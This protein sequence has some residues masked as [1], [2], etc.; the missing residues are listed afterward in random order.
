M[1]TEK[2]SPNFITP[3]RASEL[4]GREDVS[5]VDASWYLPAQGRNAQEEYLTMRIPGACYF[6]IDKIAGKE[7]G[8]PHMLPEPA[9]F[10]RDAGALGISH[11]DL[12]IVYDGPGLF[13]AARVW[14]TFRVMGA[15][16]V[17]ILQGGFDRWRDAGFPVETGNPN[18][19]RVRLF[20][21]NFDAS[22]VT[23]LTQVEDN[24]KSANAV[25]IDARPRAR[26]DGDAT[27]PRPG[28]RSGH[29]PGSHSLP[30]DSL[31]KDGRLK[32]VAE[33]AA[34]FAKLDIGPETPVI[35]SCGSGVT[36]AILFLALAETGHGKV[37]LY[38]GSWAEWGQSGGPP[39]A[40]K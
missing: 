16:D 5:F 9:Q 15:A 1:T 32:D 39:V 35:T 33:L 27:E 40:R 13:S 21:T 2:G 28:L 3:E 12:I 34:S 38:D 26:F 30:A 18:P 10:S 24:I 6:D 8:L 37:K 17:R 4:I 19:P 7:S 25:L 20:E 36:A 23:N 22:Q 31:I 11:D 14:W 29:I